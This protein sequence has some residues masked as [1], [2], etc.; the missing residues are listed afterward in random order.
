MYHKVVA[1][2]NDSLT[3]TPEKLIEQWSFLKSE[4]Y[5]ALHLQ[6]FLNILSGS[7][8]LPPKCFLLTF[9]DGYRNNYEVVYPL[10]QQFGFKA[11]FFI[12]SEVLGPVAQ[13]VYH[14]GGNKM[15]LEEL[16]KLDPDTVQL[17]LHG[18]HHEHFDQLNIDE[19]TDVM[20]KSI[21]AFK[22]SGLPF[23]KVLAYPYGARP[24]GEVSGQMKHWMAENGIAAAF[25]I[26]NQVCK[27]PAT[28]KY[29]LK[30]IDIKGTDELADFKIKL[31]KGKLKPF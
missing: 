13:Q 17:A 5:Q 15:N 31:R 9:D 24:A 27:I 16:V 22:A 4:G 10:L 21:Y 28:D 1:G 30:R 25:R 11:T 20:Q 3:I 18:H 6:D 23:F 29:E 8:P 14:E 19:I 26:G 7:A 12:I 2:G